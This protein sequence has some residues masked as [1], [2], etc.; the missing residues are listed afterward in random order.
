MNEQSIRNLLAR[1]MLWGV[2]LAAAVL[3]AGGV[4]FLAEHGSQTP[5]D[6]KFTGE[7]ADLR[8][9]V[10]IFQAAVSG[11]DAA[12]IQIGVLLLLLN[13]LVRVLLAGIGYGASKDWLYAGVSA[14]VFAVLMVSFFL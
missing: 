2:L 11:H 4:V 6:R 5:G 12:V 14:V 13:P 9:P 10:A 3:L 7:P 1:I 8:H